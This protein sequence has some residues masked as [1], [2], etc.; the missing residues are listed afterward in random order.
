M[1]EYDDLLYKNLLK[2]N[3]DKKIELSNYLQAYQLLR[4]KYENLPNPQQHQYR[5]DRIRDRLQN[6]LDEKGIKTRIPR[7][8]Y[9]RQNLSKDR[10]KKKPPMNWIPD[11]DELN[12]SKKKNKK[13]DDDNDNKYD[14][15][16]KAGKYIPQPIK[17]S[18]SELTALEIARAHLTNASSIYE[19]TG[20][21]EKAQQ[22]LDNFEETQGYNIDK[23][24]STK[25]GLLVKNPKGEHEVAFRGTRK[26]NINDIFTDINVAIGTEGATEHMVNVDKMMGRIKGAGIDLVHSSGFSLGG[27]PASL[28][29]TRENIPSTLFNPWLSKNHIDNANISKKHTIIRTTED[30]SSSAL[31]RTKNYNNFTIKSL[32][33]VKGYNPISGH[34]LMNFI[35]RT[36]T[37]T[38][39]AMD[40]IEEHTHV[41]QSLEDIQATSHK[42][43]K[44]QQFKDLLDSKSF[45]EY[46]NKRVGDK[47]TVFNKEGNH[48][49][50]QN[51][52]TDQSKLLKDYLEVGKELTKAEIENIKITSK[53]FVNQPRRTPY[54]RTPVKS[55][56][57]F[58]GDMTAT[59]PTNIAV[60]GAVDMEPLLTQEQIKVH[61]K[62]IAVNAKKVAGTAKLTYKDG[63]F[64][65]ERKWQQPKKYVTFKRNKPPYTADDLMAKFQQIKEPT[66][67]VEI[68]MG[69]IRPEMTNVTL[70]EHPITK[71]QLTP[72]ISKEEL[73]APVRRT[74]I[75]IK[76]VSG[77]VSSANPVKPEIIGLT[78]KER[79]EK[80]LKNSNDFH[81]NEANKPKH[82]WSYKG[83]KLGHGERLAFLGKTDAERVDFL[84][85]LKGK[86]NDNINTFEDHSSKLPAADKTV[87]QEN[88][89]RFNTGF[90]SLGAGLGAGYV[91]NSAFNYI[92]P[93]HKINRGVRDI[94]EGSAT[95]AL[96]AATIAKITGSVLTK[97]ALGSEMLS[98]GVGYLVGDYTS[99][100]ITSGLED[101]GASKTVSKGVGS[102]L[103]GALGG[104]AAVTAGGIATALATGASVGSVLGPAGLLIGSGI[105]A[106]FGAASFLYSSIFG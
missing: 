95:G 35:N 70:A 54:S 86:L 23:E 85:E 10:F 77:S 93:K 39:I 57:N 2:H 87:L 18:H 59:E 102:T 13:K 3:G 83:D 105:G 94:A 45:S 27:T 56:L 55:Y 40:G 103:G 63:K 97:A 51:K 90:T 96:T 1:S 61:P 41:K 36:P 91:V 5:M 58:L 74:P 17:P 50:I 37:Q 24:Y 80:I 32:L 78:Q 53:D 4:D 9:D 49:I 92:D 26:T 11:E 104:A 64:T 68:E 99:S 84:E 16:D 33:P 21:I 12:P 22:Y 47:F 19:R 106:A 20:D 100:A 88:T 15:F 43:A 25:E 62:V 60:R 6:M 81:S 30:V 14:Y 67:N 38:D 46:V 8:Y 89:S 98:A 48:V 66:T 71:P 72:P 44:F 101:L 82:P 42:L 29:A 28:I 34:S 52:I 75:K 79:L 65:Q 73:S 69:E 31:L 7:Y 76:E